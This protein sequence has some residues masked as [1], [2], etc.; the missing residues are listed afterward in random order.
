[1]F[2]MRSIFPSTQLAKFCFFA[3]DNFSSPQIAR[4]EVPEVD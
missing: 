2:G 4:R 3:V 1:M